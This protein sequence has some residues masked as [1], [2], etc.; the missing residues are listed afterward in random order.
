MEQEPAHI[1]EAK[2][3]VD[4]LNNALMNARDRK[5]PPGRLGL[6]WNKNNDVMIVDVSGIETFHT[7]LKTVT[8]KGVIKGIAHTPTHI[9][10]HYII[11][12][13]LENKLDEII[14]DIE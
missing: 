3:R 10:F 2:E 11:N 7:D 13:F 1:T 6:I 9:D 4:E 5:A 8:I 12:A 14:E